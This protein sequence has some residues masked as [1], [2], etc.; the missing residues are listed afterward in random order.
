MRAAREVFIFL[1]VGGGGGGQAVV[2]NMSLL[3]CEF[4]R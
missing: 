2:G 3:G 4:L 1:L